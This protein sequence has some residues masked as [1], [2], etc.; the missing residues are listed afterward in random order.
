MRG[1][2]IRELSGLPS[3][4]AI[5]LWAIAV[6]F[7]LGAVWFFWRGR[8]PLPGHCRKCGYDL[9]GITGPCP[10]CGL[11]ERGSVSQSR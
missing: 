6:P 9:T 3:Y 10:E 4:V 1:D 5:P 2:W 7:V 11:E 8:R